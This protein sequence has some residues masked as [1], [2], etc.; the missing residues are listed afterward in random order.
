[1]TNPPKQSKIYKTEK[2]E[3]KMQKFIDKSEFLE[4]LRKKYGNLEDDRGAYSHNGNNYEWLS[5]KA[6]VDIIESLPV[7]ED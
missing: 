3:K 6:I 4:A 5:V 7:Y 1:L 2:G